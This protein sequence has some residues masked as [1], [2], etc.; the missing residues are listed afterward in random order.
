M[1]ARKS[2]NRNQRSL[3]ELHRASLAVQFEVVTLWVSYAK[4]QELKTNLQDKPEKRFYNNAIL[5]SFLLAARNLLTFLYSHNAR[6]S[7]IIA[8]DFFDDP[9]T[10]RLVL[11]KN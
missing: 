7:D 5:H 4:L 9:N 10:W 11:C 8:E 6:P 1:D 2:Q 3:E